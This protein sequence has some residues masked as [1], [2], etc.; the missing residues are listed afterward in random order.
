LAAKRF[1]ARWSRVC[2][3]SNPTTFSTIM[4]SGGTYP[5]HTSPS[6]CKKGCMHAVLLRACS[7][8]KHVSTSKTPGHPQATKLAWRQTS[9]LRQATSAPAV[10][11]R[12]EN[13]ASIQMEGRRVEFSL[14]RSQRKSLLDDGAFLLSF[15]LF[16]FWF[17]FCVRFQICFH[18]K[19]ILARVAA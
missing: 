19:R 18:H 12:F 15:F 13:R 9:T 8:E 10:M 17:C 6:Q 5:H 1:A 7:A 4:Y 3:L 14:D 11:I 16:L 2:E